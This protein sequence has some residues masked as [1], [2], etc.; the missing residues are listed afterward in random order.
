MSMLINPIALA[1]IKYDASK[2]LNGESLRYGLP[3]STDDMLDVIK[4]QQFAIDCL[5]KSERIDARFSQSILNLLYE[6]RE[7]KGQQP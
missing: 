1:N 7:Q 2:V 4:R 3:L 5:E 6:E